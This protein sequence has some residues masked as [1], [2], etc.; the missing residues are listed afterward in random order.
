MGLCSYSSELIINNKLELDNI[1][2]NEF[3][4]YAPEGTVKVYIYGLY[5]C[6]HA[7]AHDNTLESFAKVLSM[8][9]QDILD[10]FMYWQEQGLVQVLS[11]YPV[12][13][14]YMPLKNFI[15][16]SKKFNKDKYS[17]FN[18][19]AQEIITGRMIT[20]NEYTEYYTVIESFH[21]EPE[22]LLMIMSY[23]VG[24]KGNN[25]GHAYI[26]TVAKNWAQENITTTQK[27]EER[28]KEFELIGS[29]V[30]DVFKALGSKRKPTHE[31]NELF[32]KWCKNLGFDKGTIIYVAKTSK[33][34]NLRFSFEMLDGKLIKYYEMKLFGIKEIEDFENN[35][36]NMTTLAKEINRELGLYYENL[37]IIVENYICKWT[38]LGF[39]PDALKMLAK[40]CFSH[41]IRTLSGMDDLVAK[42][43]KLGLVSFDALT[44]HITSLREIDSK[45][46]EILENLGLSRLVNSFDRDFYSTWTNSW[47]MGEDLINYACSIA[48]GKSQPM[49]YMNKI[50]STWSQNGVKT[51]EQ[52]KSQALPIDHQQKSNPAA[53]KGHNYSKEQLD[54]LFDSLEEIEI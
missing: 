18:A 45:I 12:S 5:M 25:V 54:S 23:C 42:M 17:A 1:F 41:S 40:Y 43:F 24:L 38:N 2:V 6:S 46:K 50:L 29:D 4:P 10:S 36:E 27:V 28:L 49:Q 22:A 20:P 30:A 31:D 34:K 11:T 47:N 14:K 33:K 44:Q 48:A 35:R 19:Q 32:T 13:I 53:I 26:T 37:D 7:N 8:S 9:E 52:A 39:E 16:N 51:L 3:L 15:N 21:I